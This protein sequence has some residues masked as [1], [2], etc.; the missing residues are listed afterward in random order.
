[1]KKLFKGCLIFF[2]SSII[3][4][5]IGV[6]IIPSGLVSELDNK[7]QYQVLQDV[8]LREESSSESK[9]VRV[10]K[11]DE[12]VKLTDSI[13]NWYLI[14]D[15]NLKEGFVSKTYIYKT[16]L[17]SDKKS[18]D[19]QIGAVFFL[20]MILSIVFIVKA[21][22]T[23]C[24][25]CDKRCRIFTKSHKECASKY[26]VSRDF[27]KQE[28]DSYF[29][30]FNVDD[31]DDVD[32]KIGVEDYNKLKQV[33]IDGYVNLSFELSQLLSIKIDEFLEDD[34]LSVIEESAIAHFTNQFKLDD[35][36]YFNRLKLKEKVVRASI[37]RV[38]FNQDVLRSRITVTDSL[39][40]KFLK[41]EFLVYLDMGVEYFEKRINTTYKG[42]S[43]GV[44]IKITKGVYY[45]KSSFRGHAVKTLKT[46]PIGKGILAITDKHI[47]FSSTNKN[48]R[49]RYD[50]IVSITPYDNGIGVEK[51]GV[52]SKP[53]IFKNLDGWFYY[54]FIKN[55]DKIIL[56]NDN[57]SKKTRRIS[58]A[59]KDKVWNR[60]SGKCIE[61]GS[62]ED[63]E[64]DHIIPFSKGGANTY[65]NI[66]LLCEPC[67]RAKSAK[68]G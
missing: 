56:E 4:A 9:V 58:Q 45:R 34:V 35:C 59:V 63:L 26:S 44:S 60:D 21:L 10:L 51:D 49:I 20:I 68:I 53:L 7:Y 1:M 67:N 17:T 25:Y 65:R 33:A 66:Q 37:L 11:Q 12:V 36:D 31:I 23:K 16:V 47:Y 28:V 27:I 3:I 29:E 8:N 61:C 52:S 55:S 38:L 54:N 14:K 2:L 15:E 57:S 39:P 50:R 13:N 19:T 22:K 46:V 42:G 32:E 48:F 40:F 18:K 5:I 24:V 41:N 64:F 43:D 30:R 6:S 62:Q